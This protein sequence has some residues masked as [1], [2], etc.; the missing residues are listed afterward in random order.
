MPGLKERH[1]LTGDATL[2]AI[3]QLIREGVG[4]CCHSRAETRKHKP[5]NRPV[6]VC[7]GNLPLVQ[8]CQF[9]VLVAQ[10]L[11]HIIHRLVEYLVG[12][13]I[14]FVAIFGVDVGHHLVVNVM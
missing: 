5:A 1:G 10:S 7:S 14:G 11:R 6:F 3:G 13:F 4:R 12:V 2:D 9:D 8:R